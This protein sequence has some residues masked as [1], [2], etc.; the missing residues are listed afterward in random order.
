MYFFRNGIYKY[1][2]SELTDAHIWCK[3][4]TETLLR[5]GKDVVVSNTFTEMWE[6]EYYVKLGYKTIIIDAKGNYKSIHD[7]PE[8][9]MAKMIARFEDIKSIYKKSLRYNKRVTI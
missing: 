9:I 1:R 8:K 3:W 5:G 4:H 7:V 2:P 6:L